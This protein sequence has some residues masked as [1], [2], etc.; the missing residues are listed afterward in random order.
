MLD[1]N[2]I[3]LHK[4]NRQTHSL[5]VNCCM[6]Y[7]GPIIKNIQN[8]IR[9]N[10][11][12]EVNIKCPGSYYG[13]S[14]N[15]CKCVIK[16]ADINIPISEMASDIFKILYVLSNN[17]IY[18]CPNEKCEH[19]IE[20]DSEYFGNVLK[21]HYGCKITWCKNCLITPYHDNKS[22]IEVESEHKKSENGKFIWEMNNKG[23]LKFCPNCRAPSI[24]NNG[25]N[26]MSCSNCN[27]IWCWLCLSTKIDYEH[28]NTDLSGLC[29]GKLW[30]GVDVNGNDINN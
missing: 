21:C 17:N 8:N 13:L 15:R 16:L 2:K 22:C 23:L 6:G 7:L 4:T 19:I 30:E 27:V 28:Y 9:L 26:K 12:K 24:K 14:R 29:K 20:V 3:L 10:I 11:R 25:C 18:L 5:C 1:K